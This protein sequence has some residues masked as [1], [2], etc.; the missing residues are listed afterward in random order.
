MLITGA[1]NLPHNS[2]ASNSI[3]YVIFIKDSA[4]LFDKRVQKM[5]MKIMARILSWKV[6]RGFVMVICQTC[7]AK[8][9]GSTESSIARKVF[10]ILTNRDILVVF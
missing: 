5:P 7:L 1:F 10:S 3:K 8:I 6:S 4:N 2:K 9:L